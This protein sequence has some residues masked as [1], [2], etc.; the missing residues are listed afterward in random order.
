MKGIGSGRGSG[1]ASVGVALLL[2]SVVGTGCDL[3]SGPGDKPT[4]AVIRVEGTS[5]NPLK[6]ITSTDF[7]EQ[8]NALSMEYTAVLFSA[9]TVEI[10][11]PYKATTDMGPQASIYVELLQPEKATA[12]V[13]L[14]VDLDNGE[15]YDR[16]ADLTDNAAL[17]YW[18]LFTEYVL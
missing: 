13:R 16:S 1:H 10:T 6:L 11:L 9:D 7:T 15:G 5:P 2:A 12:S 8:Y 14:R 4:T 18:F 3:T 17:I